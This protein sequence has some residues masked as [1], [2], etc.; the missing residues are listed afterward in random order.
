MQEPI[1][2]GILYLAQKIKKIIIKISA[3]VIQGYPV[4]Y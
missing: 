3:L 1:L 2:L 4:L